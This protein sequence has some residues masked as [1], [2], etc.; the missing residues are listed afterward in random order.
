VPHQGANPGSLFPCHGCRYIQLFIGSDSIDL[1]AQIQ[2]KHLPVQKTPRHSWPDFESP[3]PNCHE[4]Q[5]GSKMTQSFSHRLQDHPA[6]SYGE[7]ARI[8][9]SMRDKT[10]PYGLN[11]AATA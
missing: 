3:R 4:P 7:N 9:L 8:S 11:N 5:D 6:I 1:L 10:F 2:L